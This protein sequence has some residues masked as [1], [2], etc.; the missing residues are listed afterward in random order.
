MEILSLTNNHLNQCDGMITCS[1]YSALIKRQ[2]IYSF[3]ISSD[4][5]DWLMLLIPSWDYF[6]KF[7][8]FRWSPFG[9][10]FLWQTCAIERLFINWQVLL[11]QPLLTSTF[12]VDALFSDVSMKV[13]RC[14]DRVSNQFL[15]F[16]NVWF[17][18][19]S[20]VPVFLLPLSLKFLERRSANSF[21]ALIAGWCWNG[22]NTGVVN[23]AARTEK[24]QWKLR[25][26]DGKHVYLVVNTHTASKAENALKICVWHE[27]YFILCN[28]FKFKWPLA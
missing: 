18:A 25:F 20:H 2:N 23:P 26:P 5:H 17:Q 9:H 24:I 12:N 28:K 13:S 22:V 10:F 11:Y 21:R 4:N 1:F 14:Q 16:E 15:S 3:F 7:R 8:H 6:G 27:F 19:E